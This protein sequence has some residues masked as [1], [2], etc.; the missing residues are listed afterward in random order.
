MA[1][2]NALGGLL[3]NEYGSSE[4]MSIAH[5][6]PRGHLHVNADWVVLEPVDRNY[7]PAPPGERSHTVLLTN[8]ANRVQPIIRYDLGDSVTGIACT[9]GSPLPAIRVDGR[10]DDVLA[11]T[12]RNGTVVKLSP[13]ALTTVME[14]AIPAHRF[15]L[16]QASSDAIE[17]RLETGDTQE[18]RAEWRAAKQA[19]GAFLAAQSLDNVHLRL[20]KGAPMPDP[21]S[22]KLREVLAVP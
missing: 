11:L 1:I 13:L 9:C 15:Q 8:L 14:E 19:L 18:R 17:L 22:G 21:R 20:A 16:V 12:S 6:C 3:V 7:E 10:N 2:A 4:C 5:S